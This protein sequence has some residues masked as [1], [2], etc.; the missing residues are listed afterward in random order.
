M[1]KFLATIILSLTSLSVSSETVKVYWPFSAASP[2]AAMIRELLDSANQTQNKYK[3]L[4]I[5]QPGAGGSLAA[6]SAMNDNGINLLASTSSFYIRPLLYPDTSH[7]VGDYVPIFNV[8]LGQPLGIFSKDAQLL[9]KKDTIT[10]GIIPGSITNFVVNSLEKNN[11][12]LKFDKIPY[13]GTPEATVNLMG[14]HI[15]ASVD[16]VGKMTTSTLSGD[17]IVIG[18]TGTRNI[19]NYKTFEFLGFPGLESVVNDYIIFSNKKL[20]SSTQME[21][22]EIFKNSMNS[23]VL[24]SCETAYGKYVD[25]SYEQLQNL[26]STNISKWQTIVTSNDK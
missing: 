3:F 26:N 16:F 20:N 17:V 9:D 12:H 23:T 5:H 7:T 11:A 4:F 2:Q 6:K 18:I 24:K 13:K 14:G 22:N 25:M 15:D 1:K 10:I 8:C 21:I 19:D